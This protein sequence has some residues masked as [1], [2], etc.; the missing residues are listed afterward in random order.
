MT[1]QEV[2]DQLDLLDTTKAYGV[3][4]LS[5]RL[6]KEGKQQLA[7]PLCRLFNMS[8]ERSIF[9][10]MWKQANILPIYKKD[11][12]SDCGNYRPVSLLCTNSKIF[13]R[14]IFKHVYNFFI[15]NSL[16]SVWQSGFL[17]GASTV[18]QLIEMY[19]R[20]CQA[21]SDR[22]ESRVVFLDISKAFDRVWHLGLLAKLK[23][24]GIEDG[25]LT[26]FTSS[27]S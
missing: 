5:P 19:H 15:D 10:K 6:L 12:K 7:K 22:K 9:P 24:N 16:I 8:L 18:T 25:L 27:Q 13:E 1:E 2:L 21:V 23:Q 3:D 14:I 4:Q 17:P 11:D 26:W 20:F